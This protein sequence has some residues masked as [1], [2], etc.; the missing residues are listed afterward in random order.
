[1]SA[2]NGVKWVRLGDYIELCDE[3]NREGIYTLDD[4]FYNV[5]GGIYKDSEYYNTIVR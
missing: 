4:D 3:R 1:M 2:N 5:S